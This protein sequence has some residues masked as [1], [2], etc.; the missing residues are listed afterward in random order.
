MNALRVPSDLR[1]LIDGCDL[2]P[3]TIGASAAR[4]FRLRQ[5]REN[6]LFLKCGPIEIG[7][8]QEAD[9]LRWLS[10]QVKVPSVIAFVAEGREEFLLTEALPG[11][12]GTRLGPK[13]PEAVVLGLAQEL[14]LWHSLPVAGCPFDQGLAGQLR[15]AKSRVEAGLVDEDDFDEERRDRPAMELWEELDR[16]RPET[17]DQAVTHGDPCLPNVIFNGTECAGLIDCG[18]VGVS[19]PYH[20][21]AL[22]CRSIRRNLGGRWVQPFLD[23]YGLPEADPGKLAYYR[24]LDELF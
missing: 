16:D 14:R 19:D 21:I 8:K 11:R 7:L 17:E 9:R 22:A 1:P 10:G 12:D 15:L 6:R 20:D 13:S 3:V 5:G 23:R 24:L 18:R 4:V 2:E